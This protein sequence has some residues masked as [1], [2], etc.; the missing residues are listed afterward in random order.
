LSEAKALHP[1]PENAQA[2]KTKAQMKRK[3]A[4]YFK[5]ERLTK[6]VRYQE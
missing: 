3:A 5:K 6:D 2:G 4:G 1:V